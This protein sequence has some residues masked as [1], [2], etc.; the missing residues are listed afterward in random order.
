MRM[1]ESNRIVNRQ[2]VSFAGCATC[3]I[4]VRCGSAFWGLGQH[5]GLIVE[6]D[7]GTY[8]IDG[9][10][11][12]ENNLDWTKTIG[13][14]GQTGPFTSFPRSVCECHR[15]KTKQWNDMEF[16]RDP[17][18]NN[19][20]TSFGCLTR[21]CGISIDFGSSGPP[22]GFGRK[23]CMQWGVR[24]QCPKSPSLPPPSLC[25]GDCCDKIR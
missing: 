24:L 21:K 18:G 2:Q 15:V 17:L 25:D 16:S 13:D 7:S 4:A 19:R 10:G 22:I 1:A 11:G 20:N 12:C 23:C 6:T 9:T 8:A 14:Y 5:C 3:N